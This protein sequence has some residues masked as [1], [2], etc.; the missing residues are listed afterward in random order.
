MEQ[1]LI[2]VK[3]L[4]KFYDI[5]INMCKI[6]LHTANSKGYGGSAP[7]ILCVSHLSMGARWPGC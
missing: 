7:M 6:L 2:S 1:L 5:E 3:E 4:A